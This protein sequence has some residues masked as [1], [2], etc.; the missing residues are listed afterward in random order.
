MRRLRGLAI[1]AAVFVA[2]LPARGEAPLPAVLQVLGTV[3]NAAAPVSNALVIALNLQDLA[4]VQ[5]WT[6]PD[7]SFTLPALRSGIYKIIAVKQGFVPAITTIVPTRANQKITL[8]LESE[9][10]A[11]RR[12]VNQ[13]IWELRATLPPD[14]LRELDI[15]MQPAE[16]VT[17]ETAA[18]CNR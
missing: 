11:R 15:A 17:Y 5:A 9:K 8:R 1:I 7:G 12:D 6:N 2:A 4:A 16:L 3:T 10:Q 14:V 18:R 13:E